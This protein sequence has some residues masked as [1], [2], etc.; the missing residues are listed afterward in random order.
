MKLR[1]Y[2]CDRKPLDNMDAV[3]GLLET[4][5]WAV[6]NACTARACAQVIKAVRQTDQKILFD[7]T[8]ELRMHEG[9]SFAWQSLLVTVAPVLPGT[10]P[11][12]GWFAQERGFAG[13]THAG[14]TNAT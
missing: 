5:P 8:G 12:L 3:C 13:R 6:L 10:V 14:L 1:I 7:W 4:Q 9:Q 11:V 2:S